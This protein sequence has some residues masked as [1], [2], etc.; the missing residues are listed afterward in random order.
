MM[1][2]K[3]INWLRY[4]KPVVLPEIIQELHEA[5]VNASSGPASRQ[6]ALAIIK[7]YFFAITIEKYARKCGHCLQER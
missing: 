6:A 2:M 4:K 3:N 1:D 5:L 7:E